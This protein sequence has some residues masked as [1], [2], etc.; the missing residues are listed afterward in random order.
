MK[1]FV[2]TLKVLNDDALERGVKFSM[3]KIFPY[4][5]KDPQRKARLMQAVEKHCRKYKILKF[6]VCF[7][8][9]NL[10]IKRLDKV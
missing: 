7:Q 8:S 1:T 6:L 4:T 3:I 9:K 10:R 2:N 5:E